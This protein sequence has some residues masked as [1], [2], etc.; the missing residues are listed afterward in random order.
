MSAL[1]LP[2]GGFISENNIP[3]LKD[4]LEN[5]RS[6][7]EESGMISKKDK[8]IIMKAQEDFARQIDKSFIGDDFR[9]MFRLSITFLPSGSQD[10][11]KELSRTYDA[12]MLSLR[13]D[14]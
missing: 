2:V 14:A 8:L 3:L 1:A 7:G 6:S 9:P 11:Y 4:F 5:Y 10:V 13:R 12:D